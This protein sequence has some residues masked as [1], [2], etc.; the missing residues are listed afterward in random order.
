MYFFLKES[1]EDSESGEYLY[2]FSPFM[3]ADCESSSL[4]ISIEFLIPF[5]V[6]PSFASK[7]SNLPITA[8]IRGLISL[9]AI[10]SFWNFILKKARTS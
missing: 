1:N 9:N 3:Y 4:L 7:N 6:A 2:S 10:A 8:S 5:Y